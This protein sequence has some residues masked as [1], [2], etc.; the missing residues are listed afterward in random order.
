MHRIGGSVKK[1]NISLSSAKVKEMAWNE[2]RNNWQ[3]L[4]NE[5]LETSGASQR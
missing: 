1:T 4:C 3:A 5:F 2:F